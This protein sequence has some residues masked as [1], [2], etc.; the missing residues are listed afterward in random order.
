MFKLISLAIA[1]YI[2]FGIPYSLQQRENERKFK[3]FEKEIERRQN[4]DNWE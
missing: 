3:E 1:F 4:P 2:V